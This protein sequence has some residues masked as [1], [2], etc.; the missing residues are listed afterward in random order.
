MNTSKRVMLAM[1]LCAV[2]AAFA[3]IGAAEAAVTVNFVKPENYGDMPFSPQ[4]KARVL[5]EL[6]EHFTKLGG[7]L[8]PGQDLKLD[9]LDVDLAGRMAFSRRGPE[10]FRIMRG[11]ADWPRMRV[12]YVLESKGVIIQSGEEHLSDM[13]YLHHGNFYTSNTTLRYEKRMIDDWFRRKFLSP[14]N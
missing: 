2:C 8:P 12:R 11:Q 7:K 10:D 5:A 1:S 4:A 13:D 14:T 6:Q 9:I 3:G